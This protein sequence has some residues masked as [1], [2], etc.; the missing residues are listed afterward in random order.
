MAARE[1]SDRL[2][3]SASD[4]EAVRVERTELSPDQLFSEAQRKEGMSLP[5]PVFG[6]EVVL[7]SDGK[8]Y[9]LGERTRAIDSCARR[10]I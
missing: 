5:A 1:L 9:R 10:R 6:Y 2:A 8:E 7:R 3:V 4:I